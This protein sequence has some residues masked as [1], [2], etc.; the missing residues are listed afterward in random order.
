MEAG[1]E[2]NGYFQRN[3]P[4]K[5]AKTDRARCS[6]AI[7]VLLHQVKDLAIAL[8]PFIPHTS[9]AIFKQLNAPQEK[10]DGIGKLSLPVGHALGKPEIIFKKL[11]EKELKELAAKY[12][13]KQH[14]AKSQAVSP[15][16]L[17][18]GMIDL[19]V[20]KIV[21]IERHPNAEKL[22][23]E[24]VE[25]GNGEVRQVVSGLVPYLKE[26]ELLGRIV[27]IVKNLKPATLRGKE[28]KGMLLAAETEGVVEPLT[29]VG[30]KPGDKVEI[31]GV[32][33]QEGHEITI[34]HF[35]TV[36][37]E[38]KGNVAYADGKE[39]KVNGAVIKTEKVKD[40]K[41]K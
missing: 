10:W 40:G 4:W 22:Y 41:V 35:L 29:P 39:L 17:D 24:Q 21:S 14:S 31:T 26:E 36:K 19:E 18:P 13:G 38:V 12:S 9:A 16:S 6:A 28:S 7:Y 8:E 33:R 5:T 23:V 37:M 11:E 27:V 15:P 2:A 30:A 34:E 20:G 25:M 1:K 32:K 3:E